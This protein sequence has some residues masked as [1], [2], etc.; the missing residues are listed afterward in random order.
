M[1]INVVDAF[2]RPR[3][4]DQ[5]FPNAI[6]FCLIEE[7]RALI[8]DPSTDDSTI[9]ETNFKAI[10]SCIPDA[11]NEWRL[12]QGRSL[13]G[14]LPKA[15]DGTAEDA[16]SQADGAL[17]RLELATTLFSCKSCLGR[18]MAPRNKTKST[19]KKEPHPIMY[20]RILTHSCLNDPSPCSDDD[21]NFEILSRLQMQK[22]PWNLRDDQLR[23][24]TV[25][26]TIAHN[27][28]TACGKDPAVTTTSE[29]DEQDARVECRRCKGASSRLVMTWQM[30]VC[31]N[32]S[33]RSYNIDLR[34]RHQDLSQYR[35]SF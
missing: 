17:T 6:D 31:K 14:M 4:N 7:F 29:M 24:H 2:I 23:F 32:C 5:W 28:V 19:K 12:S 21:P 3:Y 22:Q 13:L 35:M 33:R 20:P 26:S 27:V 18:D 16:T 34:P 8:V 25:A 11:A 10:S 9:T 1:A 15:M 30:A